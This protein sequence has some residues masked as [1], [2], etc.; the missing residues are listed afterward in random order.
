MSVVRRL[1]LA[2]MATAA[3]VV[4]SVGIVLWQL[5][6]A[7]LL[8][9]TTATGGDTGAHVATV[10]YL[11]TQL[12]PHLHLTGW[13][14]DWYDGFPLYTFY[15]PLPDLLAAVAGAVIGPA[16]AFKLATALGVLLLPVSAWLFGRL[17]GLER[18]RPAVLAAASLLFI[19]DQTFTIDGGNLY[20]TMAGEYAYALSLALALV[21]LGLCLRGMRTGRHRVAAAVVLAL[22]LLSHVVP[23]MFAV[24]GALVVLALSRP[25]WRRLRW[26]AAVGVLAGALT[27]WWALPFL[28]NLAYTTNMGW[29]KVRTYLALLAPGTGLWHGDRWV[30]WLAVAGLV[31]AAVQRRRPVLVLGVLAG[32]AAGA[33]VV[34]APG[35]IYNVRFLP[36]WWVCCYLLAGSAVAE[37]G[38]VLAR[39]WRAGPF[40]PTRPRWAP[41]AVGVPL[42]AVAAAAA[43]VLPPL[44]V[45]SAAALGITPSEVPSW[46]RW[47]YSGFQ[48]KAGWPELHAV[49]SMVDRVVH[50]DGCGRVMWEYSPDLDRFGT[51]M[52][53]MD[54]PMWTGG[55]ATTQE[56]VLFESSA[57]TPYHFIDQAELSATPSEAMAGLPYPARVPDVAAGVRHLQLLGVPY[58]LAS[59]TAVEAQAAADPSLRLVASSGPW[60]TPFDGQEITTTWRL[61]RVLGAPLVVA[62]THQPV[63]LQGVGAGQ[64]SWLPVAV[65]WY[66]D[67]A[68]WGTELVA[69]G[70]GSWSRQTAGCAEAGMADPPRRRPGCGRRP[71]GTAEPAD[72][73]SRVRV[74]ATSVSFRVSRPG[75]PVLVKV[76][77]FPN[78]HAV[79]A[80]GPW[81]A[82]P[83]LMVVVP[84]GH[85]VRLV[86]GSVPVD[87]VGTLVSAAGLAGAL[88][89]AWRER[90]GRRFWLG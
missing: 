19:F 23:A 39:A 87:T 20:S 49:V 8:S 53:L 40:G 69:G 1:P 88:G 70:P 84:F 30:L 36:L 11:R 51:P 21:F 80:S 79:G 16:V 2:Q 55:C 31:V 4:A 18:P 24:A 66:D 82:E 47:D 48:A 76:S 45:T 46:V 12:L 13:D 6:P 83:D 42:A 74:T 62:L 72:R 58:F 22:C 57:T 73:V 27:A 7:L 71:A 44:T 61:Y 43:V 60:R 81:R 50:R 29:T 68:A 41:G 33:V 89:A 5:D 75:V 63:V 37:A 3:A 59:S 67:P 15:F 17:A 77:Y 35:G 78:W 9:G 54:L 85:V 52:A 10:D 14:P 32:L 34:V 65:R 90:R 28:A 26:T 38:V 86:Y 56:G 25:T 64:R